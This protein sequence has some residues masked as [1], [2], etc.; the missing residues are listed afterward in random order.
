MKKP[1]CS[2]T[3]A[4]GVPALDLLDSVRDA[5]SLNYEPETAL[6]DKFSNIGPRSESV[7]AIA[8]RIARTLEQVSFRMVYLK[9]VDL[10]RV[11]SCSRLH[12]TGE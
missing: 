4:L 11:C 12:A 7:D 8:T 10:W 6:E 2:A 3:E 9:V 1:V 5:S